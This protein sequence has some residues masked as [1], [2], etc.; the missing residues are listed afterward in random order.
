MTA[1]PPPLICVSPASSSVLRRAVVSPANRSRKAGSSTSRTSVLLPEPLT[2]VTQ[3]SRPSGI[4]TVK[5]FK[6]CRLA[7]RK[8]SAAPS[9]PDFCVDCPP[10]KET[11]RRAGISIRFFPA[12]Y[13]PVN[14]CGARR[15][16]W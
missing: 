10:R 2:P 4:S 6:L 8:I 11:G 1:S 16:S 3:T 7:R 12:R 9:A 14:D 15:I 5:S 13:C